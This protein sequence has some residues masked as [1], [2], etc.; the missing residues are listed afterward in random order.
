[1]RSKRRAASVLAQTNPSFVIISMNGDNHDASLTILGRAFTNASTSSTPVNTH[2]TQLGQ[3]RWD[4]RVM[5]RTTRTV[6][7]TPTSAELL[8]RIV[9]LLDG[10]DGALDAVSGYGGS[11]RDT[12]RLSVPSVVT[13]IILPHIVQAFWSLTLKSR[14]R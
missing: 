4:G 10:L 7:S 11:L 3:N 2:V 6:T 5:N 14:R 8:D 1:M 13:R 9:P 12:P